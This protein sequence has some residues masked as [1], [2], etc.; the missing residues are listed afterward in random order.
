MLG[1]TAALTPG[2]PCV[3]SDAGSGQSAFLKLLRSFC[4]AVAG[5][6]VHDDAQIIEFHVRKH[7]GGPDRCEVQICEAIV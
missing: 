6:L 3:V 2:S 4:D 5:I 7:Y 1:T